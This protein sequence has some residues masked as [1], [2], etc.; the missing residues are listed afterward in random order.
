MA[1]TGERDTPRRD[2][3]ILQPEVAAGVRIFKGALVAF[4]G[5]YAVPGATALNLI[6]AGRAEET[7]DN[8]GG[9]AGALRVKLRRGQFLFKNLATDPVLR[10]NVGSDCFIADDETVAATN[11]G[12]TRSRAG[13]VL[14]LEDANGVWVEFR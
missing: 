1:L 7:V 6:A 11:G 2:I 3:E 10:A 14:G 4:Q 13:K 5:G 12:N 9:S 8:T